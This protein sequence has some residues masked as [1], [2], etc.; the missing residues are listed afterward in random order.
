MDFFP[1][2]KE[3]EFHVVALQVDCVHMYVCVYQV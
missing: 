3:S 2:Y 1:S